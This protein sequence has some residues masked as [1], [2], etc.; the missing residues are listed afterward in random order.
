MKRKKV[1]S[2]A[3]AG[4][5]VITMMVPPHLA[6]AAKSA[7]LDGLVGEWTFENET[8]EN[9]VEGG[10]AASAIVTGLGNYSGTV[11]YTEDRNG[12]KAVKL[13]DYGLK[14]NQQDLGDN[15][16]VSMWLK[17]D[18]NISDNQSVLFLGY[19]NPEKWLAIAGDGNNNSTT[20]I[21]A[22]GN[23]YSWTKWANKDLSA[24][25]HCV[26]IT[27]DKDNVKVYVDGEKTAE[28]KTSAPLTGSNQDIYVGV[29]NWDGEFTGSADD[30]K[31]Y[32]KTLTEGEVYQLYDDSSAESLLEK[33]GIEATKSLNMVVGREE[34]IEVT[35]PAVVKE[36]NPSVAYVTDNKDIATVDETGKVT[37]TGAGTT[38]ITT[39]VTLGSTTKEAVT[40]VMVKSGLEENLK[41]TYSFEDN[42]TNS[43]TDKD[44]TA[45][46]TK[47]AA[48]SKDVVY[49]EGKSGKA[50]R[51]GDYGLK[52]DEENLG[53]EYTVSAWVK[54]DGTLAEN[55]NVLFL[56]YHNPEK[57]LAVSGKK[58]GTNT[59]KIWENGNGYK[60]S[61]FWSPEIDT[62]G[63]HNITL[64]GKS[65]Q[66]TAYVDG[67]KLGTHDSN[68][69]LDGENQGIYL[70]VTNWDAEFEGL[71]DEVNVYDIALTEKE[72][73]EQ[74]KADYTQMLQEKLE[75]AVTDENLL[76]KN[77][78]LDNVKYDLTLPTEDN[79]MTIIWTSSDENVI[80]TDGTVTSPA[81]SKEVTLTATAKSGELEASKEIKVTVKALERA[82]LD[83]LIKSA[84]SI[85]TTYCTTVS[86]DRLKEAIQEAKDADSFDK[87]DTAYTKLN[88]AIAGLAY[89]EEYV[90]PFSVIDPEAP[91]TTKEMKV[92][93]SEKLFTIP[94]SVKDMVDVEYVS[95][96]DSAATYVD[97]TV[98]ALKEGKVTV[99][100]IVTAKYDGYAV[101]YS[102]ALDVRSD[103]AKEELK[104][105]KNP[106]SYK[107]VVGETAVLTV[108]A[109]GKDLNYQWEY[110]NANSNTWRTSTMIGSQTASI[111]VPVAKWRDGQKYRCVIT[112]GYGNQVISDTATVTIGAAVTAPVIETQPVSV[113]AAKGDTVLF[114]VT[115]KAGTGEGATYQWEYCNANSNTWRTSSMGGNQT[116]NLIVPAATWRDGQKYRC[117][118][119][120]TDGRI[121]VSDVA[122]MTVK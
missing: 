29:T 91:E 2:A 86:A 80:G 5:L 36:A 61:T 64:S 121:V 73:Q 97:G 93:E 27:G 9:D 10:T 19:H 101:E 115:L 15:F 103:S 26:T 69:P 21:W 79:G 1:M 12:G 67:I 42:L 13:G 51:L 82:E 87:V 75:K 25:W 114:E 49:V 14:L 59:C 99:T 58:T 104:V 34:N 78:S 107:G 62:E 65:G 98:T 7:S 90:D 102:T 18:G 81:E 31:V 22:N 100:A 118:I 43:I 113:T 112:D 96:D 111:S 72:V 71:V 119:T 47:L 110:C 122:V 85:D 66:V 83:A 108:E 38:K 89:V 106:E 6:F 3:L 17:P 41:A 28:N 53:K 23:G 11:T 55:Q 116:N 70:G 30:I 8:L 95:S 57:W 37:A 16:T 60:W 76:G 32:N 52:L 45:V 105:T 48:Y 117:V 33:N 84:E 35:M 109:E 39:K 44:A 74:N 20:K 46:T 77:D 4:A 54:P 68:D 24:E 120:G 94:D 88:K 63:W 92:G 56:G 40:E 50:V